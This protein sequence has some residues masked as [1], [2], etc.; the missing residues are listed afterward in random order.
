MRPR[1]TVSRTRLPERER[2]RDARPLNSGWR[3]GDDE[4]ASSCVAI[5]ITFHSSLLQGVQTSSKICRGVNRIGT[6]QDGDLH[7]NAWQMLHS[8]VF[9]AVVFV[10]HT[11]QSRDEENM[12]QCKN[13]KERPKIFG[14]IN[15]KFPTN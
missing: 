9:L 15:Y 12:F 7:I 13:T 8:F 11:A 6:R 3:G 1:L 2:S 4:A 5:V 10:V 14:P